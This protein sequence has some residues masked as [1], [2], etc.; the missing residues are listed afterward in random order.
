MNERTILL[1]LLLLLMTAPRAAAQ[2]AQSTATVPQTAALEKA[3]PIPDQEKGWIISVTP[4]LWAVNLDGTLEWNGNSVD[5]DHGFDD[6]LA[7][8]SLAGMAHFE[9]GKGSWSGFVDS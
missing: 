2:S 8:L 4:Y 7:D 9:A 3:A 1:S 5:F 6:I